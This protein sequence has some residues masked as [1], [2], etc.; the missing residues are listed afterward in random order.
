M[1]NAFS[2]FLEG[3]ETDNEVGDQ[4]DKQKLPCGK[5]AF[6]LDPD[7]CGQQDCGQG[8]QD[9]PPFRAFFFMMVVFMLMPVSVA[10]AF[11]L[12]MMFV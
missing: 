7:G 5:V 12:M 4:I 11:V 9:N 2:G 10:M 3:V 1:R 8:D 6:F